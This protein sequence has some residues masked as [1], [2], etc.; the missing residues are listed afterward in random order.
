MVNATQYE[1]V[2]LNLSNSN[3]HYLRQCSGL[4]QAVWT[5]SPLICENKTPSLWLGNPGK[6]I[7]LIVLCDVW[8]DCVECG[9]LWSSDNIQL[10]K[11]N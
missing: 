9:D 10:D 11:V 5:L 4:A 6:P 8:S 7:V 2:Q 3:A 1:E